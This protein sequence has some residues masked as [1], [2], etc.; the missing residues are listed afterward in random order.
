[1]IRILHGPG[2]DAAGSIEPLELLDRAY[3]VANPGAQYVRAVMIASADGGAVLDGRSG[4]LGNET[5]RLLFA[6][7]RAQADV[8]LVGASTVRVEGYAGERPRP[9]VRAVRRA[10]GLAEAPR[11][12]IVTRDLT[13]RP[14]HPVFTDT[15]VR[16]LVLT[17]EDAPDGRLAELAEVADVV[18]AGADRV[19]IDRALDEL[20]ARGMSRVSCEGGPQLLGQL[21]AAGRLDELALTL[22]P[23]LVGGDAQRITAGPAV[24]PPQHLHL[25]QVLAD[26]DYLFL[27]YTR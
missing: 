4:G 5:D 24:R 12:A 10:R 2:D 21:V 19:D 20:R 16:P 7:C 1:M 22:A 13:V 14:D 23:R 18:V 15:E 17:C 3:W 26:E 11:I 25:H 9:E 6:V 27:R 8:L